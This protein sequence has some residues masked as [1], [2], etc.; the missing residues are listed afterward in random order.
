MVSTVGRDFGA[1]ACE[2]FQIIGSKSV[3]NAFKEMEAGDC[4]QYQ[5]FR[6]SISRD[7]RAA[8]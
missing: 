2:C 7:L 1:E 8:L 6:I 5:R 3:M 4:E